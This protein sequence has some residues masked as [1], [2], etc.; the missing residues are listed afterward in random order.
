[1]NDQWRV[2]PNFSQYGYHVLEGRDT[3]IATA[4]SQETAEAIVR[5]HNT[6]TRSPAPTDEVVRAAERLIAELEAHVCA[7]PCCT[8]T[9]NLATDLR[10]VAGAVLAELGG[11]GEVERLRGHIQTLLDNLRLSGTPEAIGSPEWYVMMTT[12]TLEKM[13]A[14]GPREPHAEQIQRCEDCGGA[15][16]L[17]CDRMPPDGQRFR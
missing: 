5:D 10:L 17:E 2:D 1:M 12:T 6:A 13:L 14:P 16:H 9:P 15:G 11:D 3:V 8:K 7:G 4:S